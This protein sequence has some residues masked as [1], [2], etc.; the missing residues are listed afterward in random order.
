[1]PF[2]GASR[3][4]AVWPLAGTQLPHTGWPLGVTLG[5]GFGLLLMGGALQTAV[6][7][8]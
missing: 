2:D 8:P 5:L 6:R 7:H 3:H 1:M 4:R